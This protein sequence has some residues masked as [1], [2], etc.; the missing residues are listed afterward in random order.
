VLDETP[1]DRRASTARPKYGRQFYLDQVDVSVRAAQVVVPVLQETIEPA[2]VIDVGC[3][4]GSWLAAWIDAGVSDVTGVD[5]GE[6]PPD[7][8]R[9]PPSNVSRVDLG[10]PFSLDRQFDL[11]MSLEVAE[12]LPAERAAGFVA[13][14]TALAPVVAFSAAVPRQ[15]GTGHV[16][17][18]WQSWWAGLFA[19]HGYLPSVEL[20][21]LIWDDERVAAYY[22]QNLVVYATAERAATLSLAFGAPSAVLDVVHPRLWERRV[23]HPMLW[24]L[25]R[26][27][28][29]GLRNAITQRLRPHLSFLRR[30]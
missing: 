29:E 17:E 14:L 2:S 23:S 18:R 26:R 27:I 16:N 21:G 28:P 11:A 1:A 5:F 8:L 24:S 13:D 4:S 6:V 25:G 22:A 7:V 20:R 15:G 30:L 12:H 19:A 10:A 9:V 3:G